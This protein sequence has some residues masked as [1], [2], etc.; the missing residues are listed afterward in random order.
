MGT[1]N[2]RLHILRG[3]GEHEAHRF[4]PTS[5][6]DVAINIPVVFKTYND[7]ESKA[8]WPA[9]ACHPD[10]GTRAQDLSAAVHLMGIQVQ[11]AGVVAE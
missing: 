8:G 11:N 9:C 5:T 1:N 4:S 3:D 10:V 6:T 2:D 7:R